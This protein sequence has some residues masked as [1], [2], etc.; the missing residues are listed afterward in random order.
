MQRT[1]NKGT[2]GPRHH[3][4]RLLSARPR[5]LYARG[6]ALTRHQA[7]TNCHARSH[8]QGRSWRRYAHRDWTGREPRRPQTQIPRAPA[9]PRHAAATRH[10]TSSRAL[11][12]GLRLPS[13]LG[14]CLLQGSRRKARQPLS[15]GAASALG[16][17]VV[18]DPFLAST[19][20]ACP[21]LAPAEF[22][23]RK[24]TPSRFHNGANCKSASQRRGGADLGAHH[25]RDALR[26]R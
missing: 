11:F 7:R 19:P 8:R 18:A 25:R 2:C 5:P 21:P 24:N 6:L 23:Y 12:A 26:R 9:A 4:C 1:P 15:L 10:R 16:A 13:A 3:P 17:A 20:V 14:G 22:F